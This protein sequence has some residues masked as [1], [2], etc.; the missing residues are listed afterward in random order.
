M[1]LMQGTANF[2]IGV[3]CAIFGS[4]MNAFVFLTCRK[5][6]KDIHQAVHPFYLGV[7][8]IIG[9]TFALAIS[10]VECF[11]FTKT[12]AILLSICGI[13]SWIQQEG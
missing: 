3:A 4:V 10:G 11:P 12:D 8:T 9:S 2:Y 1:A 7:G 13:C 5:I 6:G